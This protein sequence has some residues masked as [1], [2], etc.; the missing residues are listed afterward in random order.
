MAADRKTS[1]LRGITMCAKKIL[2]ALVALALTCVPA[3]GALPF[4]YMVKTNGMWTV[5]LPDG[6]ILN[7]P[8]TVSQGLQEAIKWVQDNGYC[9]EVYGGPEVGNTDPNQITTTQTI[10]IAPSAKG[11][12]HF[13]SVS[14]WCNVPAKMDCIDIQAQDMLDFDFSGQIIYPSNQSAVGLYAGGTYYEG[15]TAFSVFTS[16]R[17][18]IMSIACTNYQFVPGSSGTGISVNPVK[19]FTFNYIET[20]E[21]NGCAVP[22]IVYP[23]PGYQEKNTW[24]IRG[25]H[26]P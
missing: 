3:V 19:P 26:Q 17:I 7:T 5:R 9:L 23:G 10:T 21:I 16:S 2:C 22:T 8:D 20:N 15:N 4:A 18:R 13:H 12:F 25:V 6:S 1:A 24:N 14:L 11:C